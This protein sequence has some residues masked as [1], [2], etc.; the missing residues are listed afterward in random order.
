[1]IEKFLYLTTIGRVTGNPHKI[2]IW[3]VEYADCYY[4]CTEHPEK[5]DWVRNIKHNPAV[6]YSIAEQVQ[7]MPT[8]AGQATIVEDKSLIATLRE[9]FSNKYSW[10]NG[11]FVEI[12][13]VT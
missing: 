3:Y 8:Q 9:K 7:T 1:M 11:T 13:P 5:S 4:L 6:S 10:N 12:R 2:E